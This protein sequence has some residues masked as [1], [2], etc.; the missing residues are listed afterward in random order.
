MKSFFQFLFISSLI[1]TAFSCESSSSK[2]KNEREKKEMPEKI[3]K[4][5]IY[6]GLPGTAWEPFYRWGKEDSKPTGIEPRLIEYILNQLDIEFEYIKWYNFEAYGDE[7]ISILTSGGADISIQGI[8]ITED[9]KDKVLFS[10]PYYIDGLGVMVRTNSDLMNLKDLEGKKVFAYRFSTTFKWAKVNL[11][12]SEIIS[13]EDVGLGVQPT[14][15]LKDGKIDA[16]LSDYGALKRVQKKYPNTRLFQEKFTEEKFGIAIRKEHAELH[17]RINE[18]L[19]KMRE[20][21]R[22]QDFTKGFEN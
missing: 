21:G 13:Q 10:T 2:K 15:L 1:F 4:V 3:E 18:V 6:A 20:S 16:Y 17:K 8:T 11:I 9:R 12:G 5:T 22:L 7:R 14:K 19:S